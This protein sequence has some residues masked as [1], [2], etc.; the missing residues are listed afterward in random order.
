MIRS[1]KFPKKIEVNRF[2]TKT[3]LEEVEIH[4]KA[5][6]QRMKTEA[7]RIAEKYIDVPNTTDFALLFL[8]FEGL[9][10][11]VLN[12]PGLVDEMQREYR[13]VV[14]GITTLAALLNSL[15]MGFRTLA[16]QK[17]AVKFG[18]C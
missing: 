12:T 4:R 18:I 11:E 2:S 14:A 3:G 15:Q 13:V 17:E 7:K 10:A 1:C 6:R 16:I 5:L 9:Y 8:P